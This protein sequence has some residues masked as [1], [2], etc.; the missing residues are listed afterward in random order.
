VSAG[1][2]TEPGRWLEQQRDEWVVLL[3]GE[4]ELGFAD[5][6]TLRLGAGDHVLIL[7]GERHRVDWTRDDPPCIWLAVHAA[8]LA[9]SDRIQG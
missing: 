2:A 5:G 1:H 8:E 6:A 7:A 3:E 4:A 9:A